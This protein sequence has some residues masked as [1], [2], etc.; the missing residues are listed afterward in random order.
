MTASSARPILCRRPGRASGGGVALGIADHLHV[1]VA[2]VRAVFV[3]L[4]FVGGFGVALYS[5]F[6]IVLP[7]APDSGHGRVTAWLEHL[8]GAVAVVAAIVTVGFTAPMGGLFAPILLAGIGGAL[9]WRQATETDRDRWRRLSR[10]SLSARGTDRIGLLRVV[11]GAALVVAGGVLVLAKS[12]TSAIRDGLPAVVVT[13]VGFALLTGPWWMRT[14]GELATERNE[15]IRAQERAEIAAQLH[16][17]VLQ[18][19]ALIQRNA[20]SPRE[21]A[22]LARGQ[23]RELRNL[24]YA[25]QEAGGQFGGAL[26]AVAGEVEDAYAVTVEVVVVGDVA[27]DGDLAAAVRAAREALVNAAKHGRVTSMALYA[28]VENDAVSVFVRDRGVGFDVDTVAD[29]R[30][31]VRGSIIDRV[32]RHGGTAKIRSTVGVGTEVAITMPRSRS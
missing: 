23:E 32:E 19:L 1:R 31:G 6:W 11:A 25:S 5:V 26:R 7:V 29:D 15:R 27:V 30:Q 10:T 22:R 16:D 14:A 8:V 3:A 17:S 13:A 12:D 20:D 21:V 9:L 4:A 18:T 2:S 28:E 24:L